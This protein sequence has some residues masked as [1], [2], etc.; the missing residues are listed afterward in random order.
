MNSAAAVKACTTNQ[1]QNQSMPRHDMNKVLH[2]NKTRAL[3]EVKRVRRENGGGRGE[4]RDS[5]SITLKNAKDGWSAN[6]QSVD[7]RGEESEAEG[8]MRGDAGSGEEG[9][10][11]PSGRNKLL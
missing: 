1:N 9:R 10:G 8:A 7:F 11:G 3:E 4:L 5:T 6:Y 2:P